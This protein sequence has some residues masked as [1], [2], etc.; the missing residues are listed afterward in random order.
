MMIDILFFILMILAIIKGLRKGFII[1]VFS[2][3]AFFIGLAAAMK[4]SVVVTSWLHS[5][6]N[7]GER[8]LPFIAFAL[9][10]IGVA[11]LVRWCALLIEK[12]LQIAM[13]GFVNKLAGVFL[14]CILYTLLLS[15]VLFYA[16]QI[17]IIKPETVAQ[18][19]SYPFIAPWGP[20]AINLF[21]DIIPLFKN[22]FHQLEDFFDG[23]AKNAVNP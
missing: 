6:T 21:G 4:L 10:M 20:K 22:M 9:V 13:L 16:V 1:A 2:F 5:N 14:Y 23:V 17:E 3:L 15:V 11:L 19:K 8:W 18:S 7:V 12:T